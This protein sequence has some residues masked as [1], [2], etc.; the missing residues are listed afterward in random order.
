[1]NRYEIAGRIPKLSADLREP[2]RFG[3][4]FHSPAVG[5]NGPEKGVDGPPDLCI[6]S[7][8]LATCYVRRNEVTVKSLKFWRVSLKA[9]K[10]LEC[11][12]N[13]QSQCPHPEL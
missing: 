5:G 13:A 12:E 9:L 10:N 8:L 7:F 4:T 3:S 6:C 1:M 2:R 11:H